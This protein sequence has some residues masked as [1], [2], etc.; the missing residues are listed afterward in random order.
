MRYA[1]IE[2]VNSIKAKSFKCDFCGKQEKSNSCYWW[3]G[4]EMVFSA[5]YGSNYDGINLVLDICDNCFKKKFKRM[6]KE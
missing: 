2:K 3:N 1:K 5:G 6:I 4:L